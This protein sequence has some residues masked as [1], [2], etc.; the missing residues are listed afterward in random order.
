MLTSFWK[1]QASFTKSVQSRHECYCLHKPRSDSAVIAPAVEPRKAC[2]SH[3]SSPA[4]FQFWGRSKF[5]SS[6]D[7][8]IQ[9]CIW[10]PCSM[11]LPFSR[12]PLERSRRFC[13]VRHCARCFQMDQDQVTGRWRPNQT[14]PCDPD[15]PAP[16][17][18][19]WRHLRDLCPWWDCRV[20]R[21]P[22]LDGE[23]RLGLMV[24]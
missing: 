11:Y 9:A 12:P 3:K 17:R 5:P 18:S 6:R 4:I 21:W 22:A 13:C 14:S 15:A 24:P 19:S 7:R 16:W 1:A 8:L 10:H 20:G 23:R 2:N